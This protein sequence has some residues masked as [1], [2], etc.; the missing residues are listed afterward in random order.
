MMIGLLGLSQVRFCKDD[1]TDPPYVTFS[2]S[3][4][5]KVPKGIFVGA[6][7]PRRSRGQQSPAVVITRGR[8][9]PPRLFQHP[10]PAAP[11]VA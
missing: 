3:R 8:A 2:K 4:R 6:P 1:E 9:A 11:P 10:K 7:L 5:S